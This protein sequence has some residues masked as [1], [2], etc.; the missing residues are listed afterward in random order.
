MFW[1]R[2][3]TDEDFASEIEPHLQSKAGAIRSGT[4]RGLLVTSQVTVSLVLLIVAATLVRNGSLV[5]ATNLGMETAGVV[6]VR[7]G[8]NSALVRRAHEELS[9]DPRVG[10][11]AVASRAPLFGMAP[12]APIRRPSG[13]IVASY[14]LVSPEYFDVLRIPIVRGRL[15]HSAGGKNRGSCGNRECGRSARA[16]AGR[17]P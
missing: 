13:V 15:V 2:R 10:V 17:G 12:P 3:R 4:L 1:R 14:A 7:G 8:T 9:A 11:I 16:L 5:R 6:S